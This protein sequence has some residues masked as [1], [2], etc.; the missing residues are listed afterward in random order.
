MVNP[1][2]ATFAGKKKKDFSMKINI[3]TR[4]SYPGLSTP[5]WDLGDDKSRIL[6]EHRL[7][8]FQ[9]NLIDSLKNQTF[10]E[11]KF[12]VLTGPDKSNLE[13]IKTLDY[14]GLNVEFVETIKELEIAEVQVQIDNDDFAG[15]EWVA[16]INKTAISCNFTNFLINY[17]PVKRRYSDGKLFKTHANY[18]YGHPSMFIAIVQ[19]EERKYPAYYITHMKWETLIPNMITVASPYVELCVHDENVFTDIKEGKDLE[20]KK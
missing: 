8:L 5:G 4:C 7:K 20:W 6:T 14:S 17:V 9:E 10:K 1:E 19:K 13:K 11:F 12:T 16:H 15:P 2:D 3:I 18:G